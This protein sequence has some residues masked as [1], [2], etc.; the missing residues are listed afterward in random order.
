M[1]IRKADVN[2][3]KNNTMSRKVIYDIC[4]RS[5]EERDQRDARKPNTYLL[6]LA[7]HLLSS[8]RRRGLLISLQLE[9]ARDKPRF[10]TLATLSKEDPPALCRCHSILSH[11]EESGVNAKRV[12]KVSQL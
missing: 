8:G 1:L 4:R 6:H 12:A 7:M 5:K 2:T 10:A 11:K 3:Q 9:R